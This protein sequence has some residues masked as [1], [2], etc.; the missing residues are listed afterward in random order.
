MSLN[1]P[2]AFIIY[3][4]PESS[5]M[6]FE[7]IR[8]VEPKKLYIIADGPKNKNEETKCRST[9]HLIETSID[10]NCEVEK[11]YS[12]TNLGCARRV[13]TGIDYV[14][15]NETSAIILEDD[16]LPNHS[17][18]GF[19]EQLLAKY[20]E[21]ERVF[22]VSG[23]NFFP[24]KSTCES[25]Y[26][27]SSIVNIWGW[28]TW[29]RAWKK[30]DLRMESWAKQ[31]KNKFLKEWCSDKTTKKD[32]LKMFDLHCN[33]PNPWTWD[34]QWVYTCWANKGL[35]VMPYKNLIQNIGLGPEGTNTY[36]A[37][38]QEKYPKDVSELEFPI[39]HPVFN[40]DRKF[41]ESYHA[42]SKGKIINRIKR[43]LK[44]I[45]QQF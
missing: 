17:F 12:D 33:N 15:Q 5:K 2:I 6:V 9:R 28:A 1:T 41:E 10:W 27:L 4:R 22:H 34:Y 16:T 8:K 18:F 36:F 13:Q 39:V 37:T 38:E 32:T 45:L 24:S 35:S 21:D 23:C 26:Y 19:C 42:K 43:Y 30:Y 3:R 40:R 29:A 31:D 14:F 25:S 7:S 20:K 44:R 11:I